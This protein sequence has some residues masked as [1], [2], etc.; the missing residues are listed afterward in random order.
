MTLCDY[1]A[2][3]LRCRRCGHVAKAAKTFRQ[4]TPGLGDRVHD[5]LA[6]V[7]ITPERV[8]AALGVED[9]GCEERLAT[10][11]EWGYAVGIGTPT[12]PTG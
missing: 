12:G 6:A 11:N 10:L 8:A 4:C 1:D 9:C 2:S 7:G 5:A 3:S